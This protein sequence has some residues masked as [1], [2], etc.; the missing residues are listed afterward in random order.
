MHIIFQDNYYKIHLGWKQS[1]SLY[2]YRAGTKVYTINRWLLLHRLRLEHGWWHPH[3]PYRTTV[4]ERYRVLVHLILQTGRTL[5]PLKTWRNRSITKRA[6]TIY[7]EGPVY[8][9]GYTRC[10]WTIIR[11]ALPNYCTGIYQDG[12]WTGHAQCSLRGGKMK[13]C[14]VTVDNNVTREG[15]YFEDG[16]TIWLQNQSDECWATRLLYLQI[17]KLNRKFKY[18]LINYVSLTF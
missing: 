12:I 8:G 14:A 15:I 9:W 17:I 10:W 16:K 1:F 3:N 2:I 5:T 7:V 13:Y 6:E 4:G 11:A 18:I